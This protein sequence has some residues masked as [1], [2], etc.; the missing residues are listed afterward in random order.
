MEEN[1]KEEV[2]EVKT[3]V[4]TEEDKIKRIKEYEEHARTRRLVL[5]GE[6]VGTGRAGSGTYIDR[7]KIVSKVVGLAD[8]KNGVH[9]VIPL[10]GVYNP[11]KGDGVI[12]VITDINISRWT[13]DISSPYPASLSLSEAVGEYV[14]LTKNDL[15]KYFN[16]GD[17][18]FAKIS[19][20]T[21]SKKIDL[22][23]R[24][25]RCRKLYGGRIVKITPSKVPRV[26]GKNGSMVE[27][28]K[29]KTGCQI[30]IG[31]NGL[32]WVRGDKKDLAVEAIL[33]IEEYAHTVGLTNK[34]EE[35]LNTETKEKI[36]SFEN[37]TENVKF[38]GE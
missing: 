14:D 15:T 25:K 38:A 33:K 13:V 12:G 21:K 36:E 24:D 10:N 19:S 37:K 32:I 16:Y 11:K 30:V 27:L 22:S 23:M 18:I 8:S 31:Q 6:E 9:F 17:I 3:R 34:I 29:K 7:G 26:I 35:L 20:V 5:P 2:R 28:I 4:E 1:V